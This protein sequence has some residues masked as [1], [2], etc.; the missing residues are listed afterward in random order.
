MKD[1]TSLSPA[2]FMPKALHDSNRE[3]ERER[4][5]KGR[6]VM[7]EEGKEEE[8]R[9]DSR[10]EGVIRPLSDVWEEFLLHILEPFYQILLISFLIVLHQTMSK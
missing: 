10:F 7:R 2:V 8:K 3:R 9:K 5:R 1:R 4:E 6:G